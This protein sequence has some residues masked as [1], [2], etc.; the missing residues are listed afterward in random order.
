M[1]SSPSFID[2]VATLTQDEKN[3]Q[4]LNA[5]KA[6]DIEKVG[7]LLQAGA[8]IEATNRFGNNTALMLAAREN[9]QD[10][11]FLIL[12]AMSPA[13]RARVAIKSE[14][15]EDF[16][17]RTIE[18]DPYPSMG[19]QLYNMIGILFAGLGMRERPPEARLAVKYESMALDF[20]RQVCEIYQF[21]SHPSRSMVNPVLAIMLE[22]IRPEWL[23]NANML[24]EVNLASATVQEQEAE[25]L[26]AQAPVAVTFMRA[27]RGVLG[28]ESKRKRNAEE[29]LAQ[30]PVPVT[31]R[32]SA[33]AAAD[34]QKE[35]GPSSEK[36]KRNG[37][38]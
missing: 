37:N 13:S 34:E 27:V 4:L 3:T 2:A 31:F 8:N 16:I 32:P 12:R 29:P 10:A 28:C 33:A 7:V 21:F 38:S 35:E 22:Y 14:S 6:G 9:H 19:R 17:K 1:D 26:P 24:T 5:A 30:A 23:L 15:T 11:A 18:S 20:E 25:A 36:H